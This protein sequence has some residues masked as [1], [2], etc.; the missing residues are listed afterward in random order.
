MSYTLEI[1]MP[2]SDT[3]GGTARKAVPAVSPVTTGPMDPRLPEFIGR[4]PVRASDDVLYTFGEKG[5]A[6]QAARRRGE[7]H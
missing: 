5:S 4:R 1:D 2:S 7:V 6:H 3:I